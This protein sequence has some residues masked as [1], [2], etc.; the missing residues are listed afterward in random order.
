MHGNGATPY[1]YSTASGQYNTEVAGDPF[2]Q[3]MGA[4]DGALL[5]GS[6]RILIPYAAGWRSTTTIG[7]WD[8]DNAEAP[9]PYPQGQQL[10]LPMVEHSVILTWVMFFI[11]PLIGSHMEIH[12]R[13]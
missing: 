1:Y 3:F 8:P 6:E 5:G 11:W 12:C 2:M 9:G 13:I 4:I 7:L 10:S